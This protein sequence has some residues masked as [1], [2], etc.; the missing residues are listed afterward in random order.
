M[1]RLPA[2]L[3]R[4]IPELYVARQGTGGSFLDVL[5]GVAATRPDAVA[6]WMGERRITY[7]QLALEV[8]VQAARFLRAGMR[9]GQRAALC[10]SN[11]LEYV[12]AL[13]AAARLGVPVALPDFELSSE[14]LGEALRRAGAEFVLCDAA[15]EAR[16][17]SVTSVPR[18][19]I[20]SIETAP[21]SASEREP[22]D[23]RLL[24]EIELVGARPGWNSDFAYVFT[25]GTTGKSKPCRVTHGRA[26]LAS[27]AFGRLVM[28][29]RP[30]DVLYCPLPLCH[31]SA[32]LLGL[33]ACLRT[34]ATLVLR[35][36]FSARHFL[37]DV[38]RTRATVLLYVGELGRALVQ[39]PESPL[40]REHALRLAVGNGMHESVWEGLQ[41]RF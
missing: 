35:E 39:L 33:C 40:D 41:R 14:L 17:Q 26:L 20:G 25:S 27:S 38:R 30:D 10:G 24:R 2:L 8:D 21:Q 29:L 3:T 34:G 28:R 13:L 19:T 4:V 7:A 6:L 22:S 5:S 11:S 9:P 36:R 15:S 16:V 12:V 32:L 1:S 23:Q 37:A 18:C 31:S